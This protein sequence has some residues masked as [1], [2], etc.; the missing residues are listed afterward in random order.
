M[1]PPNSESRAEAHA[2]RG[3]LVLAAVTV[4]VLQVRAAWVSEDAFITLR[5]VDNFVNG[6]GLR[7]NPAERVQ[8]YTH[9][10][11]MFLLAVPYAI[12]R[13]PY[14]TTLAL[15]LLC[16][17]ATVAVLTYR[18][19]DRPA[20]GVIA[21]SVLG[22]SQAFG[23]Y[24]TSGLEN[25]LTHLLLAISV[26]SWLAPAGGATTRSWAGD[27]PRRLLTT[28]AVCAGLAAFNRLDTI[29]LHLPMVAVAAVTVW[30]Q[31]GL[32]VALRPLVMAFTPLAL[33]EV[34]SLVYYGFLFPNTAY[35]KL[36]TGVEQALLWRSGFIYLGDFV[37][38]EPLSVVALLAACVLTALGPS[39]RAIWPLLG[40][41]IYVLYVARV[42]GDFMATRFLSGPVVVV[43]SVLGFASGFA[44]RPGRV[45]A[46][47]VALVAFASPLSRL[48][49]GRDYGRGE[50]ARERFHGIAD[51]R[52][53]YYPQLG[54]LR[55]PVG[56]YRKHGWWQDGV[57]LRRDHRPEDPPPVGINV[58]ILGYAVGPDVHIV[59]KLALTDPMLARLP[60]P[61]PEHFRVGHFERLIPH[62]YLRAVQRGPQRL[63]DP[64]LRQVYIAL[65]EVVTGKL[66]S[67]TR[68]DAIFGFA[69]NRYDPLIGRYVARESRAR[70]QRRAQRALAEPLGSPATAPSGRGLVDGSEDNENAADG[71]QNRRSQE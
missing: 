60:I 44:G 10:L 69:V 17:F 54:L 52:A 70:A 1:S 61:D 43:A 6:L 21:L 71:D 4:C 20:C 5:T 33:W 45:A 16:S 13:E 27:E 38:R 11:W 3:L 64:D 62:G 51:E 49:L 28:V 40:V 53:Y 67:A 34:F 56:N 35:A 2:A 19:R 32:R 14:F 57:A 46:V 26:T 66:F 50:D 9:P 23:D 12:T 18:L 47:V 22:A 37:S 15:S 7:W 29:L 39:R 8:S 30:R 25:P 65:H 63:E 42:G 31:Y 48:P 59:D 55:Y 24:S 36:N 58:G 68:W 41:V